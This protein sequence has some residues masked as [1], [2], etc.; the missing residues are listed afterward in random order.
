MYIEGALMSKS[1]IIALSWILKY[2]HCITLMFKRQ[3]K[4]SILQKNENQSLGVGTI[5]KSHP[6][7]RETM[8]PLFVYA[9]GVCVGRCVWGVVLS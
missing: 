5:V 9:W 7:L 2:M 4:Q 6:T 1:R 8:L 3:T